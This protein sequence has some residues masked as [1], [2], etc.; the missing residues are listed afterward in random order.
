MLNLNDFT[1]CADGFGMHEEDNANL[2]RDRVVMFK[3][4]GIFNIESNISFISF[5]LYTSYHIRGW[6]LSISHCCYWQPVNS[7]YKNCMFN[8]VSK[9]DTSFSDVSNLAILPIL[10]F[11]LSFSYINV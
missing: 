2:K 5:L 7:S 1:Y 10:L 4:E 8:Q 6:S 3:R 9:S 11:G